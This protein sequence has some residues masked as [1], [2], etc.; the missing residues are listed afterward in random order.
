MPHSRNSVSSFSGLNGDV[1]LYQGSM[2]SRSSVPLFEGN[3]ISGSARGDSGIGSIA[4]GG[5]GGNMVV[6]PYEVPVDASDWPRVSSMDSLQTL[7]ITPTVSDKR[8]AKNFKM[9]PT[10]S[11]LERPPSYQLPSMIPSTTSSIIPAFGVA[12]SIQSTGTHQGSV[13]GL[14]CVHEGDI[15]S[16]I[17]SSTMTV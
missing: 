6:I 2:T 17:V 13:D 4:G 8:G 12:S 16:P 11:S 9:K 5:N 7:D 10:R 14:N 3:D 1:K 15:E